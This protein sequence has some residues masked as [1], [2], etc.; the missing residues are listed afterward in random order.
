MW[1]S[2]EEGWS[3]A[4]YKS[5]NFQDKKWYYYQDIRQGRRNR[6]S[7]KRQSVQLHVFNSSKCPH[8]WKW[9]LIWR[10][11]IFRQSS[12][13]WSRIWTSFVPIICQVEKSDLTPFPVFTTGKFVN[14][15]ELKIKHVVQLFT[16][17]LSNII[18]LKNL[19]FRYFKGD[20]QIASVDGYGTNVYVYLQRLSHM[21]QENIPVYN[22][23]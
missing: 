9:R 14:I 18:L 11:I 17:L 22:A 12:H 1:I 5:S 3:I 21:A 6:Q 15:K 7:F 20:L 4:T 10:R 2:R 8:L 23:R 16:S 19:N 13:A